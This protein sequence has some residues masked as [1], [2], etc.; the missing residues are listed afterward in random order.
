MG[1]KVTGKGMY[2]KIAVFYFTVDF[3]L[4]PIK[5]TPKTFYTGPS[6]SLRVKASPQTYPVL[7][8]GSTLH[9]RSEIYK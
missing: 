6:L 5:T 2:S 3:R 1:G 4:P 7:P 9:G 8:C